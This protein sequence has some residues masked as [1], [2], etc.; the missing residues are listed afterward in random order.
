M[1][2]IYSWQADGAF[3]SSFL[4]ATFLTHYNTINSRIADQSGNWVMDPHD[5]LGTNNIDQFLTAYGLAESDL[6][7]ANREPDSS[8]GVNGNYFIQLGNVVSGGFNVYGP[9]SGGAWPGT[10]VDSLFNYDDAYGMYALARR[11]GGYMAGV[12][13]AFKATGDIDFVEEL[14]DLWISAKDELDDHDGR[15]YF[16]YRFTQFSATDDHYL[17][18]TRI[19]DV[20]MMACR[21]AMTAHVLN[22][23]RSAAAKYGTESDYIRDWLVEVLEEIW[24]YRINS[25]YPQ[26]TIPDGVGGSTLLDVSNFKTDAAQQR[27]GHA[28]SDGYYRILF[29][30]SHAYLMTIAY[31]YYLWK[32]TADTIYR[33]QVAI[34]SSYW[35]ANMNLTANGIWWKHNLFT[36]FNGTRF[37][38]D[39]VTDAGDFSLDTGT[40]YTYFSPNTAATFT[41]TDV[42]NEVELTEAVSIADCR[43]TTNSYYWDTT[44]DS[45]YVNIGGAISNSQIEFFYSNKF[46]NP[47]VETEDYMN[48]N[49]Q[50]WMLLHTEAVAE[51]KSG[52]IADLGEFAQFAS[53]DFLTRLGYQYSQV[54]HNGSG[55]DVSTMKA[56]TDG[57][58][59]G[60]VTDD[61]G[62]FM[63][64]SVLCSD[65]HDQNGT[66]APLTD[67]Y[68]NG[69]SLYRDNVATGEHS[70]HFPVGRLWGAAVDHYF[71]VYSEDGIYKGNWIR[72]ME[73]EE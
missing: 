10:P 42:I 50:T 23:N 32:L 44:I 37:I 51:I 5:E 9:K 29:P 3:N 72:A 28:G 62:R 68:D 56:W 11:G 2:N 16:Y 63:E 58:T 21:L 12:A 25:A 55:S 26:P 48:Y 41:V 57:S 4:P 70:I 40:T 8:D 43:S 31:Y 38:T 24:L 49:V 60:G 61:L 39:L 67:A 22:V 53:H 65:K 46:F 66:L 18:D 71:R 7:W 20:T 17:T 15:G 30:L 33:E 64:H 19:L 14:Y 36:D 1:T 47:A 54:I 27:D 59:T 34:R 69:G 35:F 73:L 13:M 52:G 45:Y 6:V